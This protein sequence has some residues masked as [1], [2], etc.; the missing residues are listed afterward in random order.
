MSAS[1]EATAGA[2]SSPGSSARTGFT[3]AVLFGLNFMNF[4]DRQVIGAVGEKI[5]QEWSLT[6]SQLA[7]LTTAFV[8]L[9][10]LVGIPFGRLADTGRRRV[11]LAG[12]VAVWSLFTALSG[13]AGSFVAHFCCRMGVGVGEASLAPAANALIADLVPAHRRARAIS[14]FML[15]L[16]LGLGASY[17]VS[18]MVAQATGGWRPALYVA[19][20]PGFVLAVLALC[21][22]EAAPGHVEAG[23][24]VVAPGEGT[25]QVVQTLL[26]IPSLRWIILSGALLN[27]VLYAVSAF[28]TSLYIRYHGLDIEHANRWN[29]LV[30]GG[31]GGLG[32]LLGGWLGDRAGRH[33]PAGRLRLVAAGAAIATPLFWFAVSQPRGAAAGYGLLLF[34]GVVAI[35]PYYS[36]TYAAIHDLVP[37][38]MRGTAMSVYFFVFYLFTAIGLLLF[39]RL[40]DAMAARALAAGATAAE[41]S[42][43]GLHDAM[44]VIPWFCAVLVAVLV[45]AARAAARE[46][47]PPPRAGARS[48][49]P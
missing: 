30:F 25:W 36:T 8:L 3:L 4:Y 13:A 18:G 39:G 37:A 48:P 44:V 38:R 14:I 28:S 41:G 26:R 47:A 43:T 33:G 49:G 7:S 34:G 22:R 17:L 24:G 5:R 45:L 21:I 10:A 9:Y 20:V 27:L 42:A 16:P 23:P 1:P 11:I 19:A 35:Y 2:A 31:G 12:G 46:T 32:M 6:D 40:S 15:G 29:A